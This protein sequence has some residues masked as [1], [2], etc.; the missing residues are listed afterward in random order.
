MRCSASTNVLL[1][2]LIVL[3]LASYSVWGESYKGSQAYNH[4]KLFKA[5]VNTATGT[6]SF[7]YPLINVAG[8]REP[9]KIHL[10]YHFN[11][12]GMFGLPTGW[13]LDLDYVADKTAELGGKQWLIDPLWN[14]ETGFASGLKYFNQHGTRFEDMGQSKPIPNRKSLSYRYKSTHKDGST[15]Y[16]S[17]QGLLVLRIDRF[18]NAVQFFYEQPIAKLESALLSKIVDN[19]GNEYQFSYEP[20]NLAVHYPDGRE[21]RVYF[22]GTG[23]T[24]IINPLQQDYRIT[25]T[26]LAGFNL[27]RTLE[28][29]EG[30]MTNLTYDSIPYKSSNSTKQMPV[31]IQFKQFDLADGK[32]HHHINYQYAKGNNYTGYPKY[33][34]SDQGDSL[35]DS[36]DKAYRYSV[37]VIR[38]N[39][40]QLSHQVYEYNY[41]HLPIEVRSF[42]KSKPYT[43]TTYHYDISPFKYSRST[44][45]DKP[46]TVTH[47]VWN[48]EES[49]YIQSDKLE[50]KYDPYGNKCQ[51][52][53]SVYEPE[54]KTWHTLKT[55][56]YTYFTEHFSLLK[57]KIE[58]DNLTGRA[59]AKHYE[60]S[61]S[62]TTHSQEVQQFKQDKAQSEWTPWKKLDFTYDSEGRK[63][64]TTTSW[65]ATD[66]PGVQTFSKHTQY[67][68]N[69]GTKTLD[70]I[71]ISDSGRKHHTQIDTRNGLKLKDI[72]PKGEITAF[73][74]DA[75]NRQVTRTD[76]EGNVI[77]T[78]YETF[79]SD[80]RNAVTHQS[81]LGNKQQSIFDASNRLLHQR[82]EHNGKWRNLH[83]QSYNGFG[84]I[85]VKTDRFGFKTS[86]TYDE[87]ERP[88]T[89]TDHFTNIH[90]FDYNDAKLTTTV[91]I[92]GKKRSEIKTI[93]WARQTI[94]STYPV[95]KNILGKAT[96]ATDYIE[97]T[98][99]HDAFKKLIH[100][101]TSLVDLHSHQAHS[102]VDVSFHYDASQHCTTSK[103]TTFDHLETEKNYEF[104][105]TDHLFTWRKTHKSPNTSSSHEGYRYHY[106]SD[107]LLRQVETPELNGLHRL[108]TRH[109][110]DKNGHE[111]E[112][113]LQDGHVITYQYSQRGMLTAR[114]WYRN[115][116]PYDVQHHY[117]EDGRLIAVSDSNSQWMHYHYASNGVLLE[118]QYPDNRTFKIERD[119]YDRPIKQTDVSGSEQTFTYWEDNGLLST[120]TAADS[121]SYFQY[122]MDMN[123]IKGQLLKRDTDSSSTGLVETHYTY[124]NQGQLKGALS[125]INKLDYSQF[126]VTYHYNGLG[127]LTT[128]AQAFEQPN[129]QTQTL[130]I[131][132][133]YDGLRRLTGEHHTQKG[134]KDEK[135]WQKHYYYDGN[136][137]LIKETQLST[138]G[139]S[140]Q[141][142]YSHNAMDQIVN[143]LIDGHQTRPVIYDNNGRL[144]QDH[145]G[146]TYTYDVAGYL[147][148]TS[149]QSTHTYYRYLPNGA[150]GHTFK[151]QS[152][153]DYYPDEHNQMQTMYVDNSWQSLVYHN[154]NIIG[155]ASD[156]NLRQP[157]TANQSL[158]AYLH[159]EG[160]G[161]TS[162]EQQHYDAYGQV[163]E[164]DKTDPNHILSILGWNQEL[165]DPELGLTYLRHRFYNTE[166]RRFI[167]RDSLDV[168]NRY[169]YALSDPVNRIDPT[170]HSPVLNYTLGSG[171]TAL[172]ILGAAL[173]VPTGGAS[174]TVSAAAGFGAGVA[175]ALSGISL[176]GS[177]MA[178]DAG[179]KTAAKALSVSSIALSVIAIAAIAVSLAPT[180]S[181]A[182]EQARRFFGASIGGGGVAFTLPSINHGSELRLLS[183]STEVSNTMDV[184]KAVAETE[185]IVSGYSIAATVTENTADLTTDIF[186][187][188]AVGSLTV[189]LGGGQV[190]NFTPMA[191][192][193]FENTTL[194]QH[195]WLARMRGWLFK[196][197]DPEDATHL[198]GRLGE[199]TVFSE[200]EL[201][202][203][204]GPGRLDL[205]KRFGLP[206]EEAQ[207]GV[208]YFRSPTAN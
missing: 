176:L 70:V 110:Y 6:F 96:D 11:A 61:T 29:P 52:A 162:F 150:L 2:S 142:A 199:K 90:T 105:L 50:T 147:L 51:T 195:A 63:T 84:K 153:K 55:M 18:N 56:S 184:N 23:V 75:L 186:A 145:N 7:S 192:N 120:I 62:G 42:Y 115:Q 128:L 100:Q 20:H 191:S 87:L 19:Y 164:N 16:F 30:L 64:S 1:A 10:N 175:S 139:K 158:A 93:P 106:D 133:T 108:S 97:K 166:L 101:S 136:D 76:P 72:T 170:G 77:K 169:A 165:N 137:N 36:D 152:H 180:I 130:T 116:K 34:L 129:Q 159:L 117:D 17:Q 125:I 13:R 21:Q 141:I 208:S 171:F 79:A 196:L 183:S 66:K 140:Q 178:L 46:L 127:E 131:D 88:T 28:T 44:N 78:H 160:S 146:Q 168:D 9:L 92:N 3:I 91:S 65:L 32:T 156:N 25:Y 86:T 167:T 201:Q 143:V 161:D 173:A 103:V 82:D 102:P 85:T 111:I 48:N 200:E 38:I 144:M 123:G 27:I 49:T 121:K 185:A 163:L 15:Q 132:Y 114:S 26:T 59:I 80:K 207:E 148:S 14:D 134:N 203:L 71:K 138:G 181:N 193:F 98:E 197:M 124:S 182:F 60:L 39:D 198:I 40:K 54:A 58:Q 33:A 157:F 194:N 149:H 104:D 119:G 73:T 151:G 31:V 94:T 154:Q 89:T 41:L 47:W 190:T 99:T 187:D 35:M 188:H 205:F 177:Q 5:Q 204:A 12:V 43:K 22:N 172:G 155:V 24:K 74:Y 189:E 8:I 68:F 107:G 122:G 95:T 67:E 83:S 69:K 118:M 179:N 81:P 174:L 53:H 135:D 202:I 112:R 113:I 126:N 57:E 206:S 37:D 109:N 4:E 45:Y